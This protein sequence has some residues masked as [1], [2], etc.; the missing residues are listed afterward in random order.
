MRK[1][2]CLVGL[3]LVFLFSAVA[4]D[5][6]EWYMNKPISKIY[7][8]GLESVQDRELQAIISPYINAQFTDDLFWELQS[9]L[10]ALDYFEE[11]TP[12]A[13]PG[14]DSGNTVVIEFAVKER[15]HVDSITI[16][17][18]KRLRND[19]ILEVVLLK[20]GDMANKTKL[21]VDT[22]AIRNLY[23]EKGYPQADVKSSMEKNETANT[24]KIFFEI[25]EGYQTT[26]RKIRFSGNNF[27]SESTLK[28]VMQT[29]EQN[30]FNSGA[31][32]EK[33]LEADRA[34]IENYYW[35]KGYIDA[36]VTNI[37]KDIEQDKE[38]GRNYL[39]V[40]LYIEEGEQWIYGGM[41][42][43]GNQIFSTDKL[44]ELVYQKPGT[45][46]N[47]KK[48]ESD[49]QRVLDLYYENGYIFNDI[50]RREERDDAAKSVTYFVKIIERGRAH[51]ENILIKGNK[52]TKDFVLRRELPIEVGD[53]F[54]KSKVIEGLRNLYNLQYFS[55]ITPETPQGS[56][57]GLMDLI[58]NV[59]EQSAADIS[60]GIVF[61][62]ATEFPISGQI[63][64]LDRNFLGYGQYFGIETKVASDEQSLTFSFTEGWLFGQRWSGGVSFAISHKLV[65]GVA[66]DLLAPINVGVPDPFD[67]H[68]VFNA[69]TEYPT[70]SGVTYAAG[71]AFPGIPSS[72]EISTYGLV[73][74]YVYYVTKYLSIP[75]QNTMQYDEFTFSLGGSTG[76]SFYTPI[77]KFIT[78]TGLSF[79]PTYIWYD[80]T[81]YRPFNEDTR[82][83]FD[84]WD[85][86]NKWIVDLSWDT[87]DLIYNPSLGFFIDQT[88]TYT[89]GILFGDRQYIKSESKLEGFLPIVNIPVFEGWNFKLV[90]ALH[91][92]ISFILPQFNGEL[93][94][95]DSDKLAVDGMFIGRGWTKTV[96]YEALWDNWIELRM[97]IIDQVFSWDSF[98]DVV[99]PWQHWNDLT[100]S[101]EKILFGFGS[102][103]RFT[104]PQ[105]PI[106]FYLA[107]R[108]S[109]VDNQVVWQKGNLFANTSEA[110]SGIDFVVSFGIDLY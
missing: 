59:E 51:I 109:I 37:T 21:K 68:Y 65:T 10:Y 17:G 105:F 39:I 57:E 6:S 66:Q 22:D 56:A 94:A 45:I 29:K 61:T 89:G 15:P 33:K 81:L 18:N 50:S 72:T 30:F 63:K 80:K 54:S 55:S 26:I 23:L 76:Y 97:P 9:R 58:I 16:I 31:F 14:D 75:N 34:L 100:I 87:R 44:N 27:A 24:V 36:R 7:F 48:L 98:F 28:G 107:K 90:L 38:E 103:I 92:A 86:V 102:G 88:F 13:V 5:A 71:Q 70:G 78:K 82:N 53:V 77:G 32:Q 99:I 60:F 42:F 67:G 11:I 40:T 46:I 43:E 4:Q 106:R 83:N 49:F 73:T 52:K 84:T 96:G 20:K 64:W 93:K 1:L 12:K 62:G 79:S 85:W 35:E 69:D 108:F 25:N 47:K 101:P 74:D 3:F 19:E 2:L 95:T 104:M 91:S 8:T 110:G 41:Q